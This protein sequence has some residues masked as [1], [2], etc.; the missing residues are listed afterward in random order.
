LE[1][2]A[3]GTSVHSAQKG[4]VSISIAGEDLDTPAQPEARDGPLRHKALVAGLW[5]AVQNVYGNVGS[6]VAFLVLAR[7]ISP[8]R[9]GLAALAQVVIGIVTMIANLGVTPSMMRLPELSEEMLNT[10][11]WLGLGISMGLCGAVE[12]LAPAFASWM[13]QPELDVILRVVAVTIPL[14]SLNSV[15]IVLLSR[16]LQMRPQAI[17]EMVGVTIATTGAIGM[18]I[19]GF[20]VWSLIFQDF[21]TVA[22]DAL[23]L[24]LMI[25]WRP[26][27]HFEP[28]Q[29]RALLGFGYQATLTQLV[30]QSR[31][32]IAQLIIGRLLGTT[33]LGL[34]VIAAQIAQMVLTMFASTVNAVALPAFSI[35][36]KDRA[37]L[38]RAVR[39]SVR[40]CGSLAIPG[41]TMLAALSPILIPLLFGSRWHTAGTLAQI[42]CIAGALGAVQYIDG[43]I[44]WALGKARV[45]FAL[46]CGI[47]LTYVGSVYAFSSVGVI[48]VALALL[49]CQVLSAAARATALT[50]LGG[51]PVAC[52]RDV[53]AILA[54]SALMYGVMR[55]L[56][57][58]LAGT[59]PVITV[60]ALAVAGGLTYLGS[61]LIL[62]RGT[63]IEARDDVLSIVRRRQS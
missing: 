6:A 24:W 61:G 49:G 3:G 7:L 33:V 37:R 31:D 11:F 47:T 15:P 21:G 46:V 40:I 34:W 22:T 26:R 12:A 44:W 50:K 9:F 1:A 16:Q 8:S 60:V 42:T 29:A 19:A 63:F 53:P 56:A 23:I 62:Q 20:G 39:H 5:I 10:G 28:R 51:I 58:A 35:V 54:C 57:A 13:H 43:T 4:A 55:G 36:Q 30:N 45:E 32:R 27:L 38:A 17:R 41:M 59:G 48:A 14:M 25:S 18:A 2:G 52:Y